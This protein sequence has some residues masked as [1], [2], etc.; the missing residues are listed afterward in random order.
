MFIIEVLLLMTYGVDYRLVAAPYIGATW[1]FGPLDRA[2][3]HVRAVRRGAGDDRGRLPLPV[4]DLYRAGDSRGLAGSPGAAPD[5]RRS[6]Q[7]QAARLR[8]VDRHR[9]A[10][11]R[12][13]D[14]DRPGRA[15]D[16]PPVHRPGVRDRGAGR[17]GQHRRHAGRR[18]D[19][20]RG[21]EPRCDLLRPVLGARGGLR[22]LCWSRW[23]CGRKA[24]SGA[25]R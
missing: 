14:R 1:R 20:R 13:P 5:G 25:T 19:P 22:H 2:V 12:A 6:G 10:R 11:R 16:E 21:G 9:R 17:H 18:P 15:V 24:C 3:A 7:D 23:R 4:E 8:P